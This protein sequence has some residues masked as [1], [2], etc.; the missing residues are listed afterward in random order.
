MRPLRSADYINKPFTLFWGD[1]VFWCVD[2]FYFLLW[3]GPS[4][5]GSG[6]GLFGPLRQLGPLPPSVSKVVLA[7]FCKQDNLNALEHSAQNFL[8]TLVT[9]NL[10]GLN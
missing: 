1:V 3:L 8:E 6:P 2:I 5:A 7:G 9:L 10:P 4:K